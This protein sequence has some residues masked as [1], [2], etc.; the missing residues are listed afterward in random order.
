MS[1]PRP[2][3]AALFVLGVFVAGL[4]AG[5]ALVSLGGSLASGMG[6]PGPH[7]ANNW[8]PPPRDHGPGGPGPGGPG[9]PGGHRGPPPP[10]MFVNMLR[11]RLQLDEAQAAAILVVVTEQDVE[12]QRALA[13]TR[14]AMEAALTHGEERI[15]G[16]L[17]PEQVPA[18]DEIV[19]E[20]RDRFPG[21][22]GPPGR[23]RPPPER[24]A[25]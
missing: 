2:F 9:G 14:P 17:R 20:R 7:G 24:P 25:P 1:A 6:R 23:G 4:V 22:P 8:P 19:R 16:A 11:D 10:A 13:A 18:F 5:G 15:R 3:L 21:P 12:V